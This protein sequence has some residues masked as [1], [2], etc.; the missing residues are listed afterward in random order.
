MPPAL[1]IRPKLTLCQTN[2]KIHYGKKSNSN[3]SGYAPEQGTFKLTAITDGG[4]VQS[5]AF[6]L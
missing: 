1:R 5:V 3:P 6:S 2:C 4:Q